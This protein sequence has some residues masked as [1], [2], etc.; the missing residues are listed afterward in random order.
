MR[1]KHLRYGIGKIRRRHIGE[2][3]ELDTDV[4]LYIDTLPCKQREVMWL[5]YV[6]GLSCTAIGMRLNYSEGHIRRI[7]RDVLAS[8]PLE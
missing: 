5:Y 8:L 6:G 3:M 4:K 2:Y 1:G 7:K